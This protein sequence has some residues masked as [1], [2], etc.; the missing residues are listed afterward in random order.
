MLTEFTLWGSKA[1]INYEGKQTNDILGL[2]TM[3][4]VDLRADAVADPNKICTIPFSF[5]PCENSMC[6]YGTISAPA[7]VWIR[8]VQETMQATLPQVMPPGSK[9]DVPQTGKWDCK[10]A[11]YMVVV[12]QNLK[13]S[14]VEEVKGWPLD[15]YG[16]REILPMS[17]RLSEMFLKAYNDSKDTFGGTYEGFAL[18]LPDEVSTGMK[19][20]RAEVPVECSVTEK[21]TNWGI[22]GAVTVALVGVA[23]L[24]YVAVTRKGKGPKPAAK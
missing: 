6:R 20:N 17:Q 2:M 19:F 5:L 10:T 3:I 18:V 24:T 9:I 14:S 8:L 22:V 7:S 21:K 16:L 15:S 23:G 13:K 4:D 1:V 12:Y 11:A